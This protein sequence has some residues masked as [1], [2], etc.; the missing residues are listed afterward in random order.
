MGSPVP[1]AGNRAGIRGT[2]LIGAGA[3]LVASLIMHRGKLPADEAVLV[4]SSHGP[5]PLAAA[6]IGHGSGPVLT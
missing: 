4:L 5:E 3:F 2:L 1:K 6:E